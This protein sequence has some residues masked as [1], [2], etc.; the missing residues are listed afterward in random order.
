MLAYMHTYT[1]T[2]TYI[3]T[4]IYKYTYMYSLI[5]SFTTL[6]FHNIANQKHFTIHASDRRLNSNMIRHLPDE[7]LS[8]LTNLQTL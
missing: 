2:H 6:F 1:H 5:H 4:Y 3:H 8:G 7:L